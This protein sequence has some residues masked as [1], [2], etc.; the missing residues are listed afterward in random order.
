MIIDELLSLI[1]KRRSQLEN[2]K[3]S[4]VCVSL[5]Y[6]AVMLDNG[7]VGLC[8]TPTE[9]IAHAHWGRRRDFHGFKALEITR[10]A[11]SLDMI[12]KTVGIATLN[13]LS[14]HLMDSEG[15]ERQFGIDAFDAIEVRREDS[16]AV[17]GYIRPIVGKLR[18]K[19]REVHVFERNPQLRGDALPDTF[20]DS[21]LPKADV[22]VIS[23]SS[24]VNGTLDR[25]LELS[26]GAR[27]VV[28]AGPTA[29]TLPEPLFKRGVNIVAGVRAKDP[30]VVERIAEA[31]PFMAFKEH[32][33]K[34]VL[35]SENSLKG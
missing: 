28:F 29:S 20:V 12:E 27:F 31:K 32:V 24:L 10:M 23:G 21:V 2:L 15:Y 25:L 17:V 8:H 26:K 19:A 1:E 6:T 11:N 9:D 4:R 5:C 34:Y 33:E 13:A 22:A 30:K 18:A 35:K 7:Y 16:V 14:Q 3:L